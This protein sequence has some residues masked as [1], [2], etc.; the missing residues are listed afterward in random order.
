M[1]LLIGIVPRDT[2]L[3]CQHVTWQKSLPASISSA[4]A[5]S[6]FR[7]IAL[8]LLRSNFLRRAR[9]GLFLR[10]RVMTP[11]NAAR[12]DAPVRVL[13]LGVYMADRTN[14]ADHLVQAFASTQS[15]Q[16]EQRWVALNGASDSPGLR[17]V[18][19]IIATQREPKFSLLNRLLR[20]ADMDDFDFV[21]ACDDDIYLSKGFLP[22]YIAYQQKFDFAVAQPARAWHSH[23]DHSFVL[24]RPWLQARQTLFVECGPLVSFRKDAVKLLLPFD[25]TSQMWGMDLVWSEVIDRHRLKM[26]I[27]DALSIDH[28]LR[29][30]ASVYNRAEEAAAMNTYLSTRPHIP[31]HKAKIVVKRHPML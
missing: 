20:P 15:V 31:M 4:S 24:R 19:S 12:E 1:P 16:V 22:A 8:N 29:P 26:G 7:S 21:I 27:I 11:T 9:H 25:Q 5:M 23:F 10:S 14:S 18:T 2:A 6:V 28:S 30:Q 17:D 3:A 13:V